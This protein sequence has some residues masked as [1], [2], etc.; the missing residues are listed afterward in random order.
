[1]EREVEYLSRKIA[2]VRGR[3]INMEALKSAIDDVHLVRK[4]YVDMIEKVGQLEA[5]IA[6]RPVAVWTED[7]KPEGWGG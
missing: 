3:I 7:E 4:G 2:E 6:G 5:K 1:L